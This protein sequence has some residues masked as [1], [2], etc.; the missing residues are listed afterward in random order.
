MKTQICDNQN[1]M[2]IKEIICKVVSLPMLN[3]LLLWLFMF[4][5][6]YTQLFFSLKTQISTCQKQNIL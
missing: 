4:F 1:K 3:T 5:F 2:Q 6:I